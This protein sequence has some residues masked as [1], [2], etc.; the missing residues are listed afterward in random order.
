[1][2]DGIGRVTRALHG[3]GAYNDTLLAFLVDNGGK[4]GGPADNTPLS[5][6]KGGWDVGDG[7]TRVP[8]ALQWPARIAAHTPPFTQP[9]LSLDLF[10]TA[11]AAAGVAPT[12]PLDG[13]DLLPF[14]TGE[15][16]GEPHA[17]GLFWRYGA[18]VPDG[19]AMGPGFLVVR[20]GEW[21][22]VRVVYMTREAAPHMMH[23]HTV[24][25][26]R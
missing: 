20:A 18:N 11:A 5:G 13:V 26:F 10:A 4:P 21:K 2:D 22:L 7:G 17:G 14:L 6:G 1:M 16:G 24:H 3:Y 19:F 9:V 12:R 25:L 23:C 8:L 15:A